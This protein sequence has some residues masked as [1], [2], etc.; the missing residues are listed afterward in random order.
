[1]SRA[2]SP[3]ASSPGSLG[4][5]SSC[6]STGGGSSYYSSSPGS[7]S[8]SHSRSVSRS[9]TPDGIRPSLLTP[10]R[11]CEVMGGPTPEAI[12][13]AARHRESS[14]S[15]SS[16]LSSASKKRAGKGSARAGVRFDPVIEVLEIPCLA[17]L[18]T[19]E[20][21]ENTFSH[22]PPLRLAFPSGTGTSA[23][24][25]IR[26]GAATKSGDETLRACRAP[27]AVPLSGHTDI[28]IACEPV[29][30][31][32]AGATVVFS[33]SLDDTMR[34]WSVGGGEDDS[35]DQV[36]CLA[37]LKA[38]RLLTCA[39]YVPREDVIFACTLN[40][41]L[42]VVDAETGRERGALE[43]GTKADGGAVT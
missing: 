9:P 27:Q 30:Q 18:R 28:V 4:D 41:D 43:R 33:A 23:K 8:A 17:E 22:R 24:N 2:S 39:R 40:G 26:R 36:D 25:A 13:R 19:I 14:I 12:V 32:A 38:P 29:A 11:F 5:Y 7:D 1:V 10:S 42:I 21:A 31:T 35:M 15:S 6:S 34:L 37:T 20:G 3:A 16:S